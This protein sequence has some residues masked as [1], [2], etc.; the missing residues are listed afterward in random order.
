MDEGEARG[1]AQAGVQLEG[2]EGDGAM[3][4]SCTLQRAQTGCVHVWEWARASMPPLRS[5]ECDQF[6]A[7]GSVAISFPHAETGKNEVM[8]P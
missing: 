6:Q 2:L 3:A 4:S 1:A 8:L 5:N 7:E